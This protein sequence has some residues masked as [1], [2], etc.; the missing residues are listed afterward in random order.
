MKGTYCLIV[1]LDKDSIIKI[2]KVL[3]EIE[4]KKGCYVYI[5]SA[6][7]SLE[8]R[9]R[10]HLSNDKRKHWHIDYLLLNDSTNVL[11]V[12]MHVSD[13]KMECE[14]AR[15]ISEN[16]KTV[17]KFGCSDCNCES[18]LIYFEN[19]QL[20]IEKI[21]EACK[22]LKIQYLTLEDFNHFQ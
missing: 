18:H 1:D 22:K 9:V 3:G 7:N 8:G 21:K 15:H 13:E 20:A 6:M 19:S 17:P 14:L 5:G 10:R 2:G 16:E 4:F 11:N 12:M